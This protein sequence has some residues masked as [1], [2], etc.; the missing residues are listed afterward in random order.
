MS[1]LWVVDPTSEFDRWLSEEPFRLDLST[2][3]IARHVRPDLD[4]S[5][6]VDRLDRL[7]EQCPRRSGL[8]ICAWLSVEGFGPPSGA[9][10]DPENS[11]IDSV[12]TTR[13]GIPISLSVIALEVAR[14]LDVD[15]V[16]I[17]MPGEFLVAD[18]NSPGLYAAIYRG[19]QP[20]DVDQ[21]ARFFAQLH[22]PQTPFSSSYLVEVDGRSIV[23]RILNNLLAIYRSQRDMESL[24][25]VV[26][27]RS[28]LAT[29]DT[30]GLVARS[31]LAARD[32]R[33]GQAADLLD[34]AAQLDPANEADLSGS[35]RQLRA[36]LN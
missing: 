18:P 9:Y 20:L 10:Y 15:L 26:A 29:D 3:A 16:G 11:F 21:I 30:M 24:R 34:Q 5:H 27:L 6:I 12:L 35:A 32:G 4:T 19:A 36:R 8:G 22:G 25:W 33:F 23:V 17:G 7:A 1:S 31:D 14:R 28:L 2:A 13:A